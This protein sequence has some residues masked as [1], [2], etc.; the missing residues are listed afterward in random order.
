VACHSMDLENDRRR[1]AAAD[2]GLDP[3]DRVGAPG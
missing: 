2:V 3:D 1:A